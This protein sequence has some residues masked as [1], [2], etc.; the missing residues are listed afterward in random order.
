MGLGARKRD[1]F[2]RRRRVSASSDGCPHR[3]KVIMSLVCLNLP[4]TQQ[5]VFTLLASEVTRYL[6]NLWCDYVATQLWA[7]WRAAITRKE[8]SS[9]V[10]TEAPRKQLLHL[11]RACWMIYGLTELPRLY[12]RINGLGK[13]SFGC[14]GGG[15]LQNC[16]AMLLY[17]RI[18][19]V[20]GVILSFFVWQCNRVLVLNY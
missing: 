9:C 7:S 15:L 12:P 2:P 8:A 6:D 11:G 14:S 3:T 4:K 16:S 1:V 5:T 18:V 13:L 10:A 17:I 20:L 19:K